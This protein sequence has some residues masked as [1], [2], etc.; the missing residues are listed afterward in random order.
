MRL[1]EREEG[2]PF[3]EWDPNAITVRII[4]YDPETDSFRDEVWHKG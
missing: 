3:P 1:E 2:V 4:R